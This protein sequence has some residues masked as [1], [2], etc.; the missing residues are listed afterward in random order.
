MQLT[1]LKENLKESLDKALRIVKSNSTL[2]I[3]NNFLISA[4][5]GRLKIA[6]TDLEIGF[7]GFISSK[8]LKDGSITVP[9][10]LFNQFVSNL[11]N[12]KVDMEVRNSVLHLNCGSIKAA[13]N[14]LSSEDFPI[15]PKIKSDE[16]LLVNSQVLKEALTSVI[17]AAAFSDARPEISGIYVRIMPDHIKFVATDSFRLAQKTIFAPYGEPEVKFNF[18]PQNIIIPSR[19]I[20][21]L[22]RIIGDKNTAV[23]IAVDGNQASFDFDD[24]QLVTRLIESRYPDYEAIIPKDFKT[25]CA[26]L[27][28][29]LEEAARLAGCFT[30]K[31][32]EIMFKTNAGKSYLEV[33]SQNTDL[34]NH[35]ARLDAE[36]K[37]DDVAITFNWRYILD[38]LKNVKDDELILELSGDQKPAVIR[39]AKSTDFFYIVMPIRNS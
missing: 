27:R 15:I 1:C 10:Q 36:I 22:I 8:I 7:T 5:K 34:G 29:N 32:N 9:A 31:L 17:N 20:G 11:P 18:K 28:D 30:S 23:K 38:G 33:F 12:Q 2:P 19:T 24:N 14:G 39:P 25:K 6:S 35:E 13:I 3:L 21:E 16:T 37:G 4:E 26:V